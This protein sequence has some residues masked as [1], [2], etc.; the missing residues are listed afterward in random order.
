MGKRPHIGV[1]HIRFQFKK[2]MFSK[3]INKKIILGKLK[4]VK[5]VINE[6]RC[7]STEYVVI[8]YLLFN[9]LA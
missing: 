3:K 5:D 1:P 6:V 9:K 2:I 8:T 4:N 7:T